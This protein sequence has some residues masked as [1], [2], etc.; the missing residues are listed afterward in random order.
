MRHLAGDVARV[1]VP[2]EDVPRLQEPP[3][4]QAVERALVGLGFLRVEID[5]AGF[6]S[7]SLNELIQIGRA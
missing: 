7:G 3:L 6:R 2:L 5:P 1:E 4:R